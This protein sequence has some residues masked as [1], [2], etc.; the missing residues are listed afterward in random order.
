MREKE[1]QRGRGRGER[2]R[3]NV[4]EKKYK[5]GFG[6]RDKKRKSCLDDDAYLSTDSQAHRAGKKK[7]PETT[8]I[9]FT[10]SRG[11]DSAIMVIIGHLVDNG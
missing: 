10:N 6:Q 8:M 2:E 1:R 11:H 7:P 4:C 5:K 3:E 9:G